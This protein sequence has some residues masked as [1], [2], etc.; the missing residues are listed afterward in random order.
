MAWSYNNIDVY[1]TATDNIL[2]ETVIDTTSPTAAWVS[3][4]TYGILR[5]RP[6]LTL[7]TFE[8]DSVTIKMRDGRPTAIDKSRKNAKLE[9]EILVADTWVFAD[10][11]DSVWDRINMIQ[12]ILNMAKRVSYQEP[13]KDADFYYMVYNTTITI[14]DADEKAAAIKV[15]MDIHPFEFFLIGNMG[16]SLASGAA[17]IDNRLPRSRCMPTYSVSGTGDLAV[18]EYTTDANDNETYILLGTVSCTAAPTATILDTF[19]GMAWTILD[20]EIVNENS[21]F[22]GDYQGLWLPANKILAITSS[23]EDAVVMFTR[24][25]I[26]R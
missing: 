24:E 1:V 18:Y 19:T 5:G 25:G 9:F 23:F 3:L 12:S 7:S 14:T 13:G 10:R 15:S 6:S 20:G 2:G 22:S 16:I 17:L 21:C 11:D 26:V 8:G 4:S